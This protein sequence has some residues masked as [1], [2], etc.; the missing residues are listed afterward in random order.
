MGR[1]RIRF[2]RTLHPEPRYTQQDGKRK[3]EEEEEE[4]K[5]QEDEEEGREAMHPLSAVNLKPSTLNAK[6]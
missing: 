3:E 5:D 6:P 4:E 1:R 2:Q